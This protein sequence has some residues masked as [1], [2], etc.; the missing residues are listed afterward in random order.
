MALAGWLGLD[1]NGG[2]TFLQDDGAELYVPDIPEARAWASRVPDMREAKNAASLSTYG[3]DPSRAPPGAPPS[4]PDSPQGPVILPG[5][6]GPVVAPQTQTGMHTGAV[7]PAAQTVQAY[8]DIPT[9]PVAQ[10]AAA[11]GAAP[12]GGGA[13][14]VTPQEEALVYART[15]GSPGVSQ[16][17]LRQKA[18]QGV[19]MPSTHAVETQGGYPTDPTAEA[20]RVQGYGMEAEAQAAQAV[21]AD[22]RAKAEAAYW[23]NQRIHEENRIGREQAHRQRIEAEVTAKMSAVQQFD[24]EAQG[25]YAEFG[26]DRFFKQKGTWATIGAAIAQGLGAY[27]AILGRTENFA[28]NIIQN[29]IDRDI[30]AQRDEYLRDKDAR[31]N[32]VADLARVTGDL[33]VAAEGA[34]A[35]Q[36]RITQAHGAELAALSKRPEIASNFKLWNAGFNQKIADQIQTAADRARGNVTIREGATVAYPQ[37]ATGGGP[38][39]LETIAKRTGA[40]KSIAQDRDEI[41]GMKGE[42][43]GGAHLTY[44]QRQ[45]LALSEAKSKAEGGA[46]QGAKTQESLRESAA[47]LSTTLQGIQRLR[48]LNSVSSRVGVG[49]MGTSEFAEAQSLTEDTLLGY[50]KIK[51]GGVVTES[52]KANARAVIPDITTATQ[53]VGPKLDVLEKRAKAEY[54]NRVRA[55]DPT[56]RGKSDEKILM[57]AGVESKGRAPGQKVPGGSR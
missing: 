2:H 8:N 10:P 29:A 18:T 43:T 50:A 24:D 17:Q 16:A 33:D 25:R 35:V 30:A 7:A 3:Q 32:L 27:A 41:A 13:P 52:D 45:D 57:E 39:S 34:K 53:R 54:V 20:L 21:A 40:L 37:A 46:R 14:L 56:A 47:G 11:G 28:G 48:E 36:M 12:A 15:G 6:K 42:A 26:P 23:M 49:K 9:L 51:T 55:H 4:V 44:K 31:N 22:Q 1:E 19:V 5:P 38:P